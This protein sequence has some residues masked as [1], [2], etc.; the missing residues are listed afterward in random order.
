MHI[1]VNDETQ[2]LPEANTLQNLVTQLDVS[3]DGAILV[4]NDDVV[5][6]ADWAQTLLKEGD[7]VELV[8]M[9][10]GG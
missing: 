3:V 1:F 8:R 6:T 9:V 4:L 5:A 7:R 10:G 2:V